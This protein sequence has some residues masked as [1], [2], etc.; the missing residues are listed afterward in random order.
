MKNNTG[1]Y[2]DNR[3]LRFCLHINRYFKHLR[4]YEREYG[5]NSVIIQV[6]FDNKKKRLNVICWYGTKT[7]SFLL[8]DLPVC[9]VKDRV[10]NFKVDI[11][12]LNPSL[13]DWDEV[14]GDNSMASSV[15]DTCNDAFDLWSAITTN[16]SNKLIVH[17]E[18][19]LDKKEAKERWKNIKKNH[20]VSKFYWD[21]LMGY[22]D[23]YCKACATDGIRIGDTYHRWQSWVGNPDIGFVRR[24]GFKCDKND[25]IFKYND[26]LYQ[27]CSCD[28]YDQ[29]TFF[30]EKEFVEKTKDLN[31]NENFN[32]LW[33]TKLSALD[34]LKNGN[35]P[36]GAWR[37]IETGQLFTNADDMNNSCLEK[38]N[39]HEPTFEKVVT[40]GWHNT[41]PKNAEHCPVCEDLY[42]IICQS[43]YNPVPFIYRLREKINYKIYRIQ[44]RIEV[45]F[46]DRKYFR[47][48]N[49]RK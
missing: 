16:D 41:N 49:E 35:T 26:K 44:R 8:F 46:A 23:C 3:R 42:R 14:T 4:K 5:N 47:R 22:Y 18:F 6:A 10:I 19:F 32:E 37:N 2:L 15:D 13:G 20:F 12:K 33:K 17:Q 7:K 36:G 11:S 48:K 45:Y 29:L 21:S 39:E 31:I 34:L 27:P 24:V 43:S 1:L 28:E 25:G 40:L 9:Y 38:I 30:N